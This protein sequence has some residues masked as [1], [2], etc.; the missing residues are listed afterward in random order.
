MAAD[1]ISRL[2]DVRKNLVTL[3]CEPGKGGYRP[4]DVT[5]HAK[6]GRSLDLAKIHES[7]TA[8]RLSGGTNMGVTYLEITALGAL[9]DAG[10]KARFQVAG[11]GPEFVLAAESSNAKVLQKLRDAQA[12]GE[13]VVSIT[14]RVEGWNGR[15]PDVLR[16]I[17]K[18]SGP[19]VLS[20]TA[21]ETAK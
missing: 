2:Y 21:F 7:L 1:A 9:I 6:K 12:R 16:A 5:F 10:P 4:G 14:G 15:F 19:P 18:A 13:K 20:V 8:T 11:T 3:T 17:G